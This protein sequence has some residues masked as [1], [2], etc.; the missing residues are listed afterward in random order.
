MAPL[1]VQVAFRLT[2]GELHGSTSAAFEITVALDPA[3]EKALDVNAWLVIPG[4]PVIASTVVP[5][6]FVGMLC[7]AT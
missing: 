6:L 2:L 1:N 3:V 5:T 4:A 7:A